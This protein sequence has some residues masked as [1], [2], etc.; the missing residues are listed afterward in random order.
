MI[1]GLNRYILQW[2]GKLKSSPP[3]RIHVFLWLFA[4]NK[5]LTRDNL[6]KRKTV[7]DLTCIFC[8]ESESLAHL[9]FQLLC[10]CSDVDHSEMVGTQVGQDFESVAKLWINNKKF[11]LINTFTSAV[12]WSLWRTRNNMVFQGECWMGMMKVVRRC[13]GTLRNWKLMMNMEEDGQMECWALE[14]ERRSSCPPKIEWFQG[15]LND[16]DQESCSDGTVLNNLNA[17]NCVVESRQLASS[18]AMLGQVPENFHVLSVS[19][20]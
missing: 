1:G 7:D 2:S 16:A 10:V 19:D 17:C 3:P 18:P 4:K 13:A 6:S 9:F 11:K 12:L 20:E 5:I 8:S 15:G 14:L